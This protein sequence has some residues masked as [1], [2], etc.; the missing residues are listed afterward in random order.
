MYWCGPILGGILAALIYETLFAANASLTRTKNF[1][2][3]ANFEDSYEVHDDHDGKK[4]P[5]ELE[6][7]VAISNI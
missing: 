3:K 4:H 5:K 1:L 2:T 6:G 7:E